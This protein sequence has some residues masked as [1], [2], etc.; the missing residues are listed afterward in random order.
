M[1]MRRICQGRIFMK[2]ISGRTANKR[3]IKDLYELEKNNFKETYHGKL[4][5][6]ENWFNKNKDIYYFA[7]DDKTDTLMGYVMMIPI[8]KETYKSLR[9]GKYNDV[10]FISSDCIIPF[11]KSYE[12]LYLY[13]M[14]IDDKYKKK[15]ISVKLANWAYETIMSISPS[16]ERLLAVTVSPNGLKSVTAQNYSIVSKISN[17][18][19]VCERVIDPRI[20]LH[21]DLSIICALSGIDV[22]YIL[23]DN[24]FVKAKDTKLAKILREISPIS[25]IESIQRMKTTRLQKSHAEKFG[26]YP[27]VFYKSNI[28][29]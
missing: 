12:L 13:A 17:D 11:N 23:N 15:G 2:F 18:I 4:E 22:S 25:I 27:L 5:T 16:I 8:T 7:I 21:T 26:S 1:D 28:K 10:N 9:T 19:H 6:Y 20:E 29:F 24:K 14:A 3:L